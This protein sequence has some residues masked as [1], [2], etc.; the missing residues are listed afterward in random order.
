MEVLVHESALHNQQFLFLHGQILQQQKKQENLLN[1][2]DHQGVQQVKGDICNTFEEKKQKLQDETQ[3]FKY[4]QSSKF[5]SVSRNLVLG[6]IGTNWFLTYVDGKLRIPNLYLFISLLLGLMFLFVDV[7]HY[8]WD[9]MSYQKELYSLDKY[10]I[11][12]E[13]ENKHEP[14]MNAINKRSHRF[15]IAK[16]VLLLTA[17]ALFFMGLIK[18]FIKEVLLAINSIFVAI[19]F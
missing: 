12:Q 16:C 14:R 9:S 2:K 10:K 15:I 13:L 1:Q 19:M 7:I 5:S 3:D 8:F 17:S 4:Q 18:I 6:I 11:E